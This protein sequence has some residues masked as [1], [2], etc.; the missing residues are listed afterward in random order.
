MRL[1]SA[2]YTLATLALVSAIAPCAWGHGVDMFARV[3]GDQIVGSVVFADGIPVKDAPVR[4]FGPDGALLE[5]S[6]TDERGQFSMPVRHRCRYRLVAEAGQ[7]HRGLFTVPEAEILNATPAEAADSGATTVTGSA[8]PSPEA[9]VGAPADMAALEAAIARQIGPLR[10]QLHE[11][12]GQVR[13]RDIMGGVGYM[14]G[15]IGL[16]VLLKGRRGA[17]KP[18]A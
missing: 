8:A 11:Y 18:E 10:E 1:N 9:G 16:Y 3:E 7:G 14:F 12:E 17:G 5:E 6:R 15:V 13:I 2:L 4:A